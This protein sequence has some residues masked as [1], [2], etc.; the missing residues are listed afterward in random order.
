VTRRRELCY[1]PASLGT[2]RVSVRLS[3]AGERGNQRAA[4][5][6]PGR[7]ATT[8]SATFFARARQLTP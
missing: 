3:A 5:A 7:I 2:S 4:A 6:A 8:R 1:G